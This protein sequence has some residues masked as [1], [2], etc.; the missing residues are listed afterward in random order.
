MINAIGL[1]NVGA[2]VF[3]RKAPLFARSGRPVI[4]NILSARR[5]NEYA[6]LAARSRGG[7]DSRPGIT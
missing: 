6:E 1:E 7:R 2:E 4:V 5:S 3:G